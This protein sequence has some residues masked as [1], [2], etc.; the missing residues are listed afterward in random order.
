MKNSNKYLKTDT[1][2]ILNKYSIDGVI[3]NLQV[4]KYKT[5]KISIIIDYFNVRI[6]HV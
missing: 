3:Y 6:F 2:F 4:K 5:M 1:S